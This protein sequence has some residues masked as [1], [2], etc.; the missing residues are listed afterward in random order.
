MFQAVLMSHCN[1]GQL[2]VFVVH[3]PA[4][5]I[6]H[7]THINNILTLMRDAAQT[8]VIKGDSGHVTCWL[9]L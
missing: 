3:I 8:L 7:Q 1:P 2:C 5:F 6:T 9:H 4:Y